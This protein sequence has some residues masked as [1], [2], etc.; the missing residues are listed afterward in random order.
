M[1][2]ST[3]TYPNHPNVSMLAFA[4]VMRCG[5]AQAGAR[6]YVT[7]ARRYAR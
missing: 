7:L 1:A 3:I 5:T 6:G 2:T 4:A